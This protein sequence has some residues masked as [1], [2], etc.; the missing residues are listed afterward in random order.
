MAKSSSSDDMSKSSAP[1]TDREETKNQYSG[2]EQ[3]EEEQEEE[4]E[5][6]EQY[7]DYLYEYLA[8]K[9][10][11]EFDSVHQKE[12]DY[13]QEST[14]EQQESTDDE[15]GFYNPAGGDAID[16]LSGKIFNSTTKQQ[17]KKKK[18][19]RDEDEDEF[20][21]TCSIEGC[22]N[23]AQRGGRCIKHGGKYISKKER[24]AL[25]VDGNIKRNRRPSLKVKVNQGGDNTGLYSETRRRQP[26]SI[27]DGQPKNTAE[28]IA[29]VGPHDV[30]VGRGGKYCLYFFVICS[31]QKA[32]V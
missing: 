26:H 23:T 14:S 9:A 1:D 32:I 17:A 21:V 20:K 7:E 8:M 3:E 15:S 29:D 22:K 30:L 13:A 6:E 5:E 16:L 2:E 24:A 28:G 4:E 31:C 27:H 25:G 11:G 19:K 10:K 12:S 18:K